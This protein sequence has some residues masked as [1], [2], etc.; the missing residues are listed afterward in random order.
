MG[1]NWTD[2]P[3]WFCS[4]FS[5]A[6]Q[7]AG[8]T[9]PARE[10]ADL[11]DELVA[12]WSA[13]DRHFHNLK[14]LATVLHRVDELS[15]ETHEPDLVRLAAWYHGA[16][17]S[18]DRKTTYDLKGGEQT[19]ASAE[20]ARKELTELGMPERNVDRVAALVDSLLTHSPDP[21]DTDSQVLNDA[22]L[23]VLAAEPQRYK[24]YA[25]AVRSE[26]SHI[27]T[28]D[29]LRARVRILERL[30]QRQRLFWSPM[31]AAWENPARQNMEAELARLLKEQRCLPPE[32]E[33]E[34]SDAVAEAAA[35][36]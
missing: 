8:A 20:L 27:P 23:S 36:R 7:G 13:P 31:G 33:P 19:T 15:Q 21:R 5:R 17:F 12:R 25:A 14:H 32:E 34:G 28:R 3:Q 6:A 30:L 26:Y 18:S 4:S 10:I 29:F 9:A 24:E 16:V 22:D 35:P 1:V 11:G 2:A